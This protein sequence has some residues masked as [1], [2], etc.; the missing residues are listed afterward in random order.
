MAAKSTPGAQTQNGEKLF[1]HFIDGAFV[2]GGATF[3]NRTPVD[4]SLIGHVCEGGQKEVDAAVKAARNALNGPWGKMTVSE[5]CDVLHRI[6]DEIVRR[7]DDF[8][9]DRI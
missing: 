9:V 8:L 4:G 1:T 5:R 7:F 6:A 3:E 2:T